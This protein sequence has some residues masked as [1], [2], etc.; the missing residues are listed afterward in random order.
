MDTY[1]LPEE[2]YNTLEKMVDAI[3][4]D[5]GRLLDPKEFEAELNAGHVMASLPSGISDDDFAGILKLA[6]LTECATDT[7]AY[8]ISSRAREFHSAWLERFTERV[9]KPDEYTHAEPFRLVLRGL[10]F[11]EA[12]LER[13]II[14]A[15]EAAFEHV[16]GDTPVNVT[17]FGMVQEYLTDHWHGLISK[18][19]KPGLPAAAHM[20]NRVKQRETLHMIWYRDMTA[21]QVGAE[22]GLLENVTYELAH[23]RLPGNSVA[24]ELQAQAERWLPL[25]GADMSRM[26]KDLAR[27]LYSIVDSPRAMGWLAI[28][29]ADKK[30]K[31]ADGLRPQHLRW[32]IEHSGGWGYS[33]VGEALLERLGLAFM[34][35]AQDERR[36]SWQSQARDRLRTWLAGQLPA[37]LA[38]A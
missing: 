29:L 1:V 8:A 16:G 28:D 6:L 37:N 7:Y 11:S 24:P 12:E 13:E 5:P 22:P 2:A 21:I 15:Q 32:A 25:M 20:A 23:F 18:L 35:K 30:D 33:L 26:V 38:S 19:L 10:G 34:F 17:T 36:P 14:Q 27:L 31:G 4:A 3:E 9:W